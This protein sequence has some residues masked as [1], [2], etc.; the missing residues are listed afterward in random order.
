MRRNVMVD[1][2][3]KRTKEKWNRKLGDKRYLLESEGNKAQAHYKT[4]LKVN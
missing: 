3:E 2:S 1:E 4:H